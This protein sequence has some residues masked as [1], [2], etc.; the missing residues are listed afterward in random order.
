MKSKLKDFADKIYNASMPDDYLTTITLE[1]GKAVGQSPRMPK[2][3]GVW[4]GSDATDVIACIRSL[5][6]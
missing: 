6:R 4:K 3:G 5:A 2:M 1:G